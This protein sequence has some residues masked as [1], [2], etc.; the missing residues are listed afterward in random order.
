MY[1]NININNNNFTP[2]YN[3]NTLNFLNFNNLVIINSNNNFNKININKSNNK[4]FKINNGK[5]RI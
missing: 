5:I 4:F 2:K 3:I 1:N